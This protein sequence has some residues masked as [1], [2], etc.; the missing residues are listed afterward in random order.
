LPR[1][2]ELAA[3]FDDRT[4]D[5]DLLRRFTAEQDEAAFAEIV[6]RHGPMLLRVCRRVLHNGHDAEDVRQAAFLIL[7]QKAGALRWHESVAGWLFQTAYRL[8][9]KARSA[10]RRRTR[11][12]AQARP[13][14]APEP[15]AELN[16][17]EF[18]AVLD[19]E[20][21]RLP[22]KYRAPILLCCLEG[23]SR[24]EA[25]R[26][27][28]WPLAAVKDRLER[29]REQL[30]RRLARRG[31]LMGT[32]LTSAWLLEGAAQAGCAEAAPQAIA[33]AAL[34][35][36][37]KKT[38]LAC[39]LPARV[40]ALAKGGKTMWRS[41]LTLLA[42]A[43][44]AVGLGAAGVGTGLPGGSSPV[45]AEAPQA[46]RAPADAS[47]QPEALPRTGPWG[48]VLAVAFSPDGKAI[49]AAGAGLAWGA[50]A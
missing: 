26:R 42:V 30:R 11:R 41:K 47:G 33:R 39:F 12:E 15:A 44:I 29:G 8:S 25:A 46:W 4:A 2:R 48:A 6:R 34:A 16:V 31:V 20:L 13:A 23:L 22:E 14:A 36:A 38:A 37:T 28:G 1:L 27:L 5:R 43:G 19:D 9:L 45:Q 32:A 18:Q 50:S 17:R 24:D 40:A 3:R 10:A 21:S 49:A 7:A 35:I